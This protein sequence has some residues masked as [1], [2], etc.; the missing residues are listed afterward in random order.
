MRQIKVKNHLRIC[1]CN[2][3]LRLIDIL[4]LTQMKGCVNM[5]DCNN[6]SERFIGCHNVCKKYMFRRMVLYISNK[7]AHAIRDLN[8]VLNIMDNRRAYR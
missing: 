5:N 7:K 3:W 6:C 4:R 8:G 2:K 1:K